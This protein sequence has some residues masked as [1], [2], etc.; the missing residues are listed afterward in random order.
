MAG[1]SNM[2]SGYIAGNVVNLCRG[3]VNLSNRAYSDGSVWVWAPDTLDAECVP[4]TWP[5]LPKNRKPVE[6]IESTVD[7]VKWMAE[8]VRVAAARGNVLPS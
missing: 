5:S 6:M 1:D 4:L 8:C 3:C 2:R 7:P